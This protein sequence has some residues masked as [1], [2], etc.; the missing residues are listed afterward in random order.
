MKGS[1]LGQ[2]INTIGLFTDLK[3]DRLRK[4]KQDQGR[5]KT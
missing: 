2:S 1:K 3:T 4:R 5:V